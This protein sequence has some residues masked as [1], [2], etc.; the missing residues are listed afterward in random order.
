MKLRTLADVRE[1]VGHLPKEHRAEDTWGH[2]TTTLDE[3]ARG[4]DPVDV[5]VAL[6]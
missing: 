3:A 1:L 4:G 6:R 5:S 2:V